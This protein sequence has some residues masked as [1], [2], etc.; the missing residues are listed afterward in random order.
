VVSFE[1]TYLDLAR[2]QF[3]KKGCVQ[4]GTAPY[5]MIREDW[6]LHDLNQM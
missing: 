3:S 5:D 2:H 4:T 1:K 6:H